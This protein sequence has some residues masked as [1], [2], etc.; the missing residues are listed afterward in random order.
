MVFLN[1]ILLGLLVSVPLGPIGVLI[2]HK[3]LERGR[4]AGFVSGMG[5]GAADT[6]YALLACFGVGYI[7]AFIEEKQLLMQLTAIL[8][9]IFLGIK[10]YYA[11]TVRQY[12]ERHRNQGKSKNMLGEF[13]TVFVLTFSNPLSFFVF[14]GAFALSGVSSGGFLLGEKIGMV[15]G[16]ITGTAL[17]WFTLSGLASLF[18]HRMKLRG[19]WWLNKISGALIFF[20]GLIAGFALLISFLN[21]LN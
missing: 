11:D 18:R 4:L 7:Q 10:I 1:G 16:V 5:A 20:F 15:L 9:I 2:I 3:T 14:A 19:M 17:W 13:A 21:V 8:L 12:R 6:L